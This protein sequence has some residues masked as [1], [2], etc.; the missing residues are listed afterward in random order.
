M[1]IEVR[2][3]DTFTITPAG[4]EVY[5]YRDGVCWYIAPDIYKQSVVNTRAEVEIDI[6]HSLAFAILRAYGH[7]PVYVEEPA[8]A[9]APAPATDP[10]ADW[11]EAVQAW[12]MTVTNHLG[13]RNVEVAFDRMCE[14][15]RRT[16]GCK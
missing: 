1:K 12:A 5:L 16:K 10:W 11:R 13:F 8:P 7:D 14:A 3:S 4:R 2:K 15:A 9:P 6:E